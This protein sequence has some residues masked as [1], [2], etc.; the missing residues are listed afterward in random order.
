MHSDRSGQT[1][2]TAGRGGRTVVLLG[3]GADR[4]L[5]WYQQCEGYQ[6]ESLTSRGAASDPSVRGRASVCGAPDVSGNNLHKQEAFIIPW[7]AAQGSVQRRGNVPDEAVIMLP[8]VATRGKS[9]QF[10]FCGDLI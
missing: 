9:L 1:A 2:D 4:L 5:L 3:P 6:G 10:P 7:V 8:H